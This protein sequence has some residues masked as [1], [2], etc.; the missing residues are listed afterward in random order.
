MP[1]PGLWHPEPLPLQQSTADPYLCRRHSNTVGS[2]SVGSLG[3][4]VHKVFFEPFEHLWWVWGLI[5]NAN[6]PLLPS[7]WGFSFALGCRVS[8]FGV[9]WH[10]PADGCLAASCNFG[11]LAGDDERTSFYFTILEKIFYT[12]LFKSKE[13]LCLTYFTEHDTL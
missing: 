10:S 4:G 9:I 7:F 2:V 11:V 1:Y 6:L 8:F 3:P 12:L 13:F 5:L